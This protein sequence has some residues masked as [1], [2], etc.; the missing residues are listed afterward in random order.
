[1]K[2]DMDLIRKILLAVEASDSGW[3][4]ES[5]TIDGYSDREVGYHC[6]LIVEAGLCNGEE[7]T[8]GHD[9]SPNA[10]LD[11]LTWQGHEFLDA[12]RDHTLWTR[13]ITACK[14]GATSVS[15]VVLV[16]LLHKYAAQ[17]IG[18]TGGN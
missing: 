12:A 2:R 18:L 15:F 5:L 14:K 8:G 1:M 17:Q 10:F 9:A 13:A 6:L 16:Q 3:S 11:R 7:T 4:P